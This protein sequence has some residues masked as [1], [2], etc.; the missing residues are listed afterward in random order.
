MGRDC[1]LCDLSKTC[2][3][4][5][6]PPAGAK[7]GPVDI[8]FVGGA[9]AIDDDREDQAW[10]SESGVLLRMALKEYGLDKYRWAA[11]SAVRCKPPETEEGEVRDP[12]VREIKAC[13]PYLA[14]AIKAYK[15]RFI[16]PMGNVALRAVIGKTGI[17]KWLNREIPHDSGAV[18]FPMFAPGAVL[19]DES[20][21]GQFEAGFQVLKRL[22]AGKPSGVTH[23]VEARVT[24][25]E[26]IAAID[27][28]I[29]LAA[30]T[31]TPD[32][33]FGVAIDFET[34]AAK[35]FETFEP[36]VFNPKTAEIKT[37]A[38]AYREAPGEEPIPLWFT[39][40]TDK[41]ELSRLRTALT[42]LLLSKATLVPFNAV[43]EVRWLLWKVL[44]PKLGEVEA[45]KFVWRV[46]DPMLF[47]H[48]WDENSPHG[49][50]VVAAQYTDMGG[51]DN[52][53]AL[54]VADGMSYD[55][56][57]L[58]TL[59]AY[60]AGDALA[61]LLAWEVLRSK[62]ARDPG[63]WRAWT[64]TIK[65]A[66]ITVAWCELHGRKI[67]FARMASLK[68]ETSE[69]IDVSLATVNDSPLVNRYVEAR[70]KSD[71]PLRGGAFNPASPEQV[72]DI[73]FKMLRLPVLGK[74]ETGAPST[75]ADYVR[76][77]ESRDPFIKAYLSYKGYAKV[78]EKLTEVEGY[79]APDGFVY[80]SYLLHGTVTG[81]LS[82][83]NP[84][85]Q[86]FAETSRVVVVSRWPDGV[87][88]EADYSQLELRLVAE[89]SDCGPLL[90]AFREKKDPHRVTAALMFGIDEEAV[91]KDQ[92]YL[93]KTGNF[94]LTYGGGPRRLMISAGLSEDDA[95]FVYKAFHRA[96]PEIGR[97]MRDVHRGANA[98]GV[99]RSVTGRLRRLPD[100]QSYTVGLRR[101]A[102]REAGNFPIQNLGSDLNTWAVNRV[103]KLCAHKGL[104]A[105]TLGLTHDSG[106]YDVPRLEVPRLAGMIRTVMTVQAPEAVY[107]SLSVPLEVEIK[108]GPTWGSLV[109]LTEGSDL[110]VAGR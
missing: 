35:G 20:K 9:P 24:V 92:R 98:S 72:A 73:L 70:E 100:A 42:R 76:P 86:N 60:N 47:H 8:L 58:D 7:T 82:S 30:E 34:S 89:A 79:T 66:I 5:C 65:D 103:R 31:A 29:V 48:L 99:V 44:I 53:V 101:K 21:K 91:T 50:D 110:V 52:E 36:A 69:K 68:A 71:R 94:L 25:D 13:S 43:F 106:T 81:R 75:K 102:E 46:E 40:P 38:L 23:L 96:Y 108:A 28:M 90:R 22:L 39:W 62:V 85:L 78:L 74:T 2:R 88:L 37:C 6:L 80:G 12:S 93:G 59:G 95:Q 77:F 54:L 87:I 45:A 27:Q 11:T 57:P 64:T 3:S 83:S 55:E 49:L 33:P 32:A 63:L 15:P 105:V 84:N 56:I 17:T 109:P 41:A 104:R 16:V 4:V 97:W 19:N 18:V 67:D 26:A 107:P 1:T 61:T 14:E 51:Y 10:V